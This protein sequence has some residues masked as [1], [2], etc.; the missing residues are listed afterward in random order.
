MYFMSKRHVF[1]LTTFA[2]Y[3]YSRIWAFLQYGERAYGYDTGI[4]RHIIGGYFDRLADPTIV[5]FGFSWISNTVRILGVSSHQLMYAGYIGV[6]V[7]VWFAMYY[8]IKLYTSP[9]VALYAIFLFSISLVQYD[10]F[11]W[12]YY[13]NS[14]ALLFV[15]VAFIVLFHKSYFLVPILL[16]IGIVHPISLVPIGLLMIAGVVF[17]RDRRWFLC[18]SGACAL[19]AVLLVSLR[20]LWGYTP[21]V[22]GAQ[23]ISVSPAERSSDELSGQ[24]LAG[25]RFVEYMLLYAPLAVYGCIRAWKK[26]MYILVYTLIISAL[27]LLQVVFYH[28]LFVWFDIVCIVY[29]AYG[30]FYLWEDIK[31]YAGWQHYG[32]LF[33]VGVYIL[34]TGA[35]LMHRVQTIEPLVTEEELWTITQLDTLAKQDD[36]FLMVVS[37]YYAPWVYGFTHRDVIAPGMFEFNMWDAERWSTFWNTQDSSERTAMLAEYGK[38]IYVFLGEHDKRFGQAFSGNPH[39]TYVD[40]FLWRFDL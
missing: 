35:L 3:L 17:D 21:L 24:F 5:P 29:A 19:S 23:G 25:Y 31:G 2:L 6:A 30:A 10:F 7:C 15:L 40:L 18:I 1:L 39:M 32:I 28:R 11:W 12:Y 27:M 13:R 34:C 4:Y 20:E 37:P 26:Q 8:A 22:S 33:V 36:A 14:I 16:L 38:P 9:T